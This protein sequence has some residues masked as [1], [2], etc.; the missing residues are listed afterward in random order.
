MAQH[1][2][3]P[4][5]LLQLIAAIAIN[6]ATAD[7]IFGSLG[8]PEQPLQGENLG[9]A[10]GGFFDPASRGIT[11]NRD[12]FPSETPGLLAHELGHQF[13]TARGAQAFGLEGVTQ[14]SSDLQAVF[15][16]M[17]KQFEEAPQ[18]AQV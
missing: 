8:L 3:G 6:P 13:S 5:T 10:V 12:V 9:S 17:L 18:E 1:P 16:S 15:D 2:S 4:D 14:P 11:L 7:S